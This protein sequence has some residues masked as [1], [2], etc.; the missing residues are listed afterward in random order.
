MSL[1]NVHFKMLQASRAAAAIG[2]MGIIFIAVIITIDVFLRKFAGTT[3]GGASE[4]AGLV[5]AVATAISYTYVLLD[6]ANIRIDVLYTHLTPKWRAYLDFFGMLVFLIFIARL[7]YSIFLLVEQSWSGNTKTVG[8]IIVPL[9]IPQSLWF[10]GFALLTL[11]AGF[12]LV[13]I[14]ALIIRRD[15]AM[16]NRIAGIP[17]IEETIEEDTHIE[18][19]LADAET[20]LLHNKDAK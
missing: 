8:V 17:S 15:W 6:R 18:A 9:W 3:I 10:A 20:R 12:L 19:Q 16:V 5:F 13:S 4:I 14:A 11:T 7:T 2:G 1:K